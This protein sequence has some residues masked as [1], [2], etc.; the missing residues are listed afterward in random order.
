MCGDGR[1]ILKYSAQDMP[2]TSPPEQYIPSAVKIPFKAISSYIWRAESNGAIHNPVS[3]MDVPE[4]SKT[5]QISRFEY[6][7]PLIPSAAIKRSLQTV[8][9]PIWR[10]KSAGVIRFPVS[11]LVL[12]Q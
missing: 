3:M 6:S 5:C 11:C 7:R 1:S 4:K 8:V 12:R 9:S 2:T 10:V